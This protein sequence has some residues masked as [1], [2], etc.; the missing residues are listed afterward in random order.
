[1]NITIF[2]RNVSLFKLGVGQLDKDEEMLYSILTNKLSDFNTYIIDRYPEILYFGESELNII[3]EY[4]LRSGNLLIHNKQIWNLLI[5]E[6]YFNAVEII[7]LITWW[8]MNLIPGNINSVSLGNYVVVGLNLR[9][10]NKNE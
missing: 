3:L 9:K 2:K 8:T 4:N 1:M 5:I 7:D 6:N 10:L